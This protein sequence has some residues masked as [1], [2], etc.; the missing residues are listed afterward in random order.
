MVSFEGFLE[1]WR[2][3][4]IFKIHEKMWWNK[5]NFLSFYFWSSAETFLGVFRMKAAACFGVCDVIISTKSENVNWMMPLTNWGQLQTVLDF[6][7]SPEIKKRTLSNQ[8]T[9]RASQLTVKPRVKKPF[10]SPVSILLK[11]VMKRPWIMFQSR[12]TKLQ[13][14]SVKSPAALSLSTC[15]LCLYSVSLLNECSFSFPQYDRC[16]NLQASR[17]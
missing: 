10:R 11:S 15:P 5:Q 17:T 7:L 8:N 13:T 6:F 3:E 2:C 16:W 12:D 1:A 14:Q 9:V 4:I